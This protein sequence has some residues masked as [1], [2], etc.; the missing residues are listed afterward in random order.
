VRVHRVGLAAVA[1]G[2]HPHPRRQLRRHIHHGL[3]VVHQPVRDVP[4]DPVAALH[5]PH[6][7]RVHAAS[8]E[9]RGVAVL[10]GAITTDGQ[11]GLV[12]VDHLDRGRTLVWIH[13]D[14]DAHRPPPLAKTHG[15]QQGGHR[16]SSRT[17]PFPAS[18]RAAPGENASQMRATPKTGGQP[19][20]KSVS[21][22]TWTESGQTP[23]LSQLNRS[24]LVGRWQ[25]SEWRT[26]DSAELRMCDPT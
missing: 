26:S 6:P 22:G 20:K 21:P 5:R 11:D 13:P 12:L 10:V 17:D 15:C 4:A 23:V 8:G 18:P 1:G 9:H 3:P 14:D 16:T 2:E 19:P 25:L 24:P 7:I